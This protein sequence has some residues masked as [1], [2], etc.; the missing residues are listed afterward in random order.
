MTLS[1]PSLPVT[2]RRIGEVIPG[3]FDRLVEESEADGFQFLRRF[4]D[5]W[6]GGVNRFSRPGE[7]LF[8]AEHDRCIVGV[9]GLNVDPYAGDSAIGRV[10]RF[11]VARE[12]R[13]QKV[14]SRLI[15]ALMDFAGGHFRTVRLF[16]PLP[17]AALFYVAVGFQSQQG[18]RH[19]SHTIAV[20]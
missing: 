5:E 6:I 8:V 19:C 4:I 2:I 17:E 7:A 3:R 15:D 10:R 11:Y 13:R 20:F 9:G 14:G 18:I 16:T 1:E 12:Y